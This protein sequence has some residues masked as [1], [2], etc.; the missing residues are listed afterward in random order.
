MDPSNGAWVGRTKAAVETSAS[1][2]CDSGWNCGWAG[3]CDSRR[4]IA[5]RIALRCADLGCTYADRR[6]CG[7]RD[8][9]TIGELFAGAEG[10]LGESGGG[11]TGGV[12]RF[13]AA[14][15]YKLDAPYVYR[16]NV[17][18]TGSCQVFD[19]G[20]AMDIQVNR[21]SL[22]HTFVSRGLETGFSSNLG[23]QPWTLK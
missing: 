11:V 13:T 14:L 12:V 1:R 4:C 6:G 16:W 19:L 3:V 10:G 5:E 17:N 23:S 18:E 21:D 7:A 20:A 2:L 22:P 9:C 15:D 8:L